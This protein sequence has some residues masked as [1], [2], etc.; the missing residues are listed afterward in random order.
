MELYRYMQQVAKVSYQTA[1]FLGLAAFFALRSSSYLAY[2]FTW[3]GGIQLLNA[4]AIHLPSLVARPIHWMHAMT[5]EWMAFMGGMI[6]RFIPNKKNKTHGNGRPILL[7]HGYIHSAAVWVFHKKRLEAIGLGPVYTISLGHPFRAIEYFAKRV[8]KKVDV[9]LKETGSKEITLVGHSMGGLVSSFY[10]TH[11]APAGQVPDVITIG[12]P[13]SGTPLAYF[14]FGQNA[15][16]M[17]PHSQFLSDLKGEIARHPHTRF[18]QIA[19]RSD[20][21]VIP[22]RTAAIQGYDNFILEDIGHVSLLYSQR[23]SKKLF[24]WLG[25]G[26]LVAVDGD[27]NP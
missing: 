9:I 5:F 20:L 24:E 11:V 22:G 4:A 21:V 18:R 8:G 7:V 14:A 23:V 19:T 13:W 12:S 25:D 1:L 2:L 10:A 6:L 26:R 27:L 3:C 16:E 15:R 17:E